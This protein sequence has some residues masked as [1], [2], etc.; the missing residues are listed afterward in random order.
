MSILNKLRDIILIFYYGYLIY[1]V[2]FTELC[3]SFYI[4]HCKIFVKNMILDIIYILYF[5]KIKYDY[6]IHHLSTILLLTTVFSNTK[7]LSYINFNK[8]QDFVNIFIMTEVSTIFLIIDILGLKN[9]INRLLFFLS[10]SY[11]RIYKL[12]ILI[13]N[14]D[15]HDFITFCSCRSYLCDY[16]YYFSVY[17]LLLVNWYWYYFLLIKLYKLIINIKLL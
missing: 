11:F 9:I 16:I 1:K 2:L 10:F 14:Q 12:S 7:Y 6:I 17:T 13:L 3:L 15:N 4:Y 8:F 5:T